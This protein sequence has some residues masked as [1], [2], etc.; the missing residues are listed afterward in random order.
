M[1]SLR[2]LFCIQGPQTGTPIRPAVNKIGMLQCT[3]DACSNIP[4]STAKSL[5]QGY[6]SNG[7]P[8]CLVLHDYLI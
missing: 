6:N 7:V 1:L 4:Q 2:G 5:A 8:P 3:Q